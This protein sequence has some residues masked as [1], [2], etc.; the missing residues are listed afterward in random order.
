[1]RPAPDAGER[2][3]HRQAALIFAAGAAVLAAVRLYLLVRGH[4]PMGHD[5]FQYLQLQYSFQNEVIQSGEVPLWL[6]YMTHGTVS[7]IWF[8]LQQGLM[9]PVWYLL[10]NVLP[11]VN[12]LYFYHVGLLFDELVLLGGCVLLGRV[13]YRSAWACAF[14][15]FGVTFTAVSAAQIWWDFHLFYLMPLILYCLHRAY[16]TAAAKWVLLS[17]VFTAGTLLGNLPY[18]VPITVLTLGAYAGAAPLVYGG[19][20]RAEYRR[21]RRAVRVRHVLAVLAPAPFVLAIAVFL[22][23]GTAHLV[24]DNPGRGSSG[25]TA[26]VAEFLTY[27]SYTSPSKY[28]DV[29]GRLTNNLDTTLYAGMLVAPFCVVAVLAARERRAVMLAVVTVA[30]GAFSVSSSVTVVV[31]YLFPLARFFRH[32]GLVAPVVCLFLVFFA[33]FGVQAYEGILRRRAAGIR[34]RGRERAALVA[35]PASLV[36]IFALLLADRVDV[37]SVFDHSLWVGLITDN[38]PYVSRA[39][40]NTGLT[41]MLL[42][43]A[44]L[45][46]VT[47]RAAFSRRHGLVLFAALM[48]AHGADTVAYK[49]E[50]EARQAPAVGADVERL[51]EPEAYSYPPTRTQMYVTNERYRAIAPLVVGNA[52]ANPLLPF[53]SVLKY[54]AAYWNTEWFL[55]LDAG[56]S[57]FRSDHWLDGVDQFHTVWVPPDERLSPRHLGFPIPQAP[58]FAKLSGLGFPKAALFA[59]VRALPATQDVRQ[60]L[61]RAE[62]GGDAV[63]VSRDELGQLDGELAS[64]VQ[65]FDPAA[66]DRIE[67]A[68]VTVRE[69]EPNRVVFDVTNPRAEPAVVYYADAWHPDWRAT[70][71]GRAAPVLRANL[72]YK[73]VAVPSGDSTVVFEFGSTR[74]YWLVRAVIVFGWAVLGALAFVAFDAVRSARGA[75]S[76][77]AGGAR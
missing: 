2:F 4:V 27:G 46:A 61:G 74:S 55:L 12:Y 62:F 58:A 32:V 42:G 9:Q 50:R 37:F 29:V 25:Q 71:N 22:Y 64:A 15:A 14:A 47:A 24:Y 28:W 19:D 53:P 23:E 54:G 6:P 75:G 77:G 3:T 7:N 41:V 44:A 63:F 16:E 21:L 36:G 65:P 52:D 20:V 57:V 56:E 51:F 40:I 8:L 17:S 76:S 73:A 66:A 26:S 33:G 68:R 39:A 59:T 18:F 31:Y 34:P 30:L 72:A 43:V 35:L 38:Q 48:L 69:F 49:V 67:G 60:A 45:I 5:T 11:G 1:M 70:V 13:Y 10:A